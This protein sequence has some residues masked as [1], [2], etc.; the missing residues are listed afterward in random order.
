[1]HLFRSFVVLPALPEPLK[2]LRELANNL[3]WTWNP[4]AI[5]LL[6]RLDVELWRELKHNP[7]AM[8]SRM[9]QERLDRLGQDPA[10]IASLG[11]VLESMQ[12]YMERPS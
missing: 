9:K 7:V 5:E 11:R 10:Y 1:M 3:W 12:N 8:L 6:R 2:P 4:E